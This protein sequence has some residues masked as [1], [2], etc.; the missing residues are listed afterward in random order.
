MAAPQRFFDPSQPQMLQ[1]ATF[2]L[3]LHAVLGLLGGFGGLGLFLAVGAA[4][5][6]YGMANQQKWGYLLSVG[7]ALFGLV[8]PF[9]VGWTLDE[10]LR[11]RTVSLMFDIALVALLVHPQSREYQRIWFS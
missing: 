11:V 4:G 2:L 8:L 3:Y 5:G 9:L 6:A 7:V 1:S 10:V